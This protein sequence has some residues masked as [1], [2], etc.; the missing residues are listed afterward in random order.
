MSLA[1]LVVFS[2]RLKG[3]TLEDAGATPIG[4]GALKAELEKS[5]RAGLQA[6]SAQMNEQILQM[7][8][9][10]QAHAHGIFKKIEDAYENLSKELTKVLPELVSAGV[11]KIIGTDGVPPEV[12]RARVE[13]VVSESC[14][15]G[16]PVNVHL[17]PQDLEDFK[18]LDENYA[19]AHPRLTFLSDDTLGRGDCM[20]ETKFGRVDATL[21]TQIKRLVE[22]LANT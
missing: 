11:W 6:I 16:E 15:A 4:G 3:V 20:M 5:Y 12:L 10:M 17:N 9:E 21:K 8:Q 18:K 19:N 14:P 7:R 22:E 13:H 1:K 2:K